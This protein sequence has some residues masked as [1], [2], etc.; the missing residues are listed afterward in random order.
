MPI[1]FVAVKK[2]KLKETQV[3]FGKCVCR[4]LSLIL[5]LALTAWKCQHTDAIKRAV[6][7]LAIHHDRKEM[8]PIS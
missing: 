2:K 4:V 6:K 5:A 7:P 8:S 3:R 1:A